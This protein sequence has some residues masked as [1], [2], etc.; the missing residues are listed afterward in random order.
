MRAFQISYLALGAL[1]ALVAGVAAAEWGL[2]PIDEAVA[3]TDAA[4]EVQAGV[5]SA[6]AIRSGDQ[7]Q[8]VNDPTVAPPRDSAVVASLVADVRPPTPVTIADDVAIVSTGAGTDTPPS[9]PATNFDDGGRSQ[10][11]FVPANS[12]N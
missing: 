9:A 4:T 11:E 8:P 7:L 2:S 12:P 6:P 3:R 5:Q 1:L 10:G